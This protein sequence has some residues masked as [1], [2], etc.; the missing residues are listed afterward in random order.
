[1]LR[2]SAVNRVLA[3]HKTLNYQLIIELLKSSHIFAH[4][5]DSSGRGRSRSFYK[6]EGLGEILGLPPLCPEIIGEYWSYLIDVSMILREFGYYL[7]GMVETAPGQYT[8]LRNGM[9]ATR[10]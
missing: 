4:Y 8:F 3:D 10:P 5:E 2:G 9:Y 6:A 7:E 1:M